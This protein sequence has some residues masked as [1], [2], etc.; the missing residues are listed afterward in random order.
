[1][2]VRLRTVDNYQGE[3]AKVGLYSCWRINVQSDTPLFEI[4]ILSLVRNSGAS[5]DVETTGFASGGRANIGFLK[6]GAGYFR[7]VP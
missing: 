1:M 4:V 5:D 6:V 7:R 2:Q 3:E